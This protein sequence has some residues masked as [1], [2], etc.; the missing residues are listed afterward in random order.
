MGRAIK[1]ADTSTYAGRVSDSLRKLR[2]ARKWSVKELQAK[3]ARQG[4]EVPASSLYAYERGE[5]SVPFE[6]IPAVAGAFGYKT[7][8]GWLPDE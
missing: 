7:A 1:A 6:L 2:T 8:A 5:I 3:L 4:V